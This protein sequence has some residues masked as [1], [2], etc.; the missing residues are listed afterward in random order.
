ML[1]VLKRLRTYQQGTG[2]HC[3]LFP[4]GS[5]CAEIKPREIVGFMS[6]ILGLPECSIGLVNDRFRGQGYFGHCIGAFLAAKKAEIL[7]MM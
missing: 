5:S 2:R 1:R 7:Y 6:C 4:G 3:Q